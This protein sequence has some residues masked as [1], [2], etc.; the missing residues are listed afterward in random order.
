MNLLKSLSVLSR[1]TSEAEYK[2]EVVEAVELL[3]SLGL[4]DTDS[5]DLTNSV[6]SVIQKLE[7]D[8]TLLYGR[9]LNSEDILEELKQ[10]NSEI[11]HLKQERLDLD[12][13]IAL[14]EL[15]LKNN[16]SDT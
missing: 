15:K 9:K 12:T 13:Q 11:A 5:E 14:E 10:V 3:V 16:T 1:P 4:M 8:E 6:K 2:R 7:Q